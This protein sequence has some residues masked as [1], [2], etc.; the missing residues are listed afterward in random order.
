MSCAGLCWFSHP[1]RRIA[2][3]LA[4]I[5]LALHWTAPGLLPFAGGGAPEPGISL[6]QTVEQP[7]TAPRAPVQATSLEPGLSGA[8]ATAWP[9]ADETTGVHP[10]APP[11]AMPP[12]VARTA[13][14]SGVA[15][16]GSSA[17]FD[18]RGPPLLT[19]L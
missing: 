10:A 13:V 19:L 3:A 16:V 12:R 8:G 2:F 4:S 6:A 5:L 9:A 15:S 11:A 7:G 18:A 1:V 14:P 17:P